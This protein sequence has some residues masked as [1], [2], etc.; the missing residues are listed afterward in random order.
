MDTVGHKGGRGACPNAPTQEGYEKKMKRYGTPNIV[1][2]LGWKERRMQ[3]AKEHV[4]HPRITQI[5][6]RGN[7]IWEELVKIGLWA[8]VKMAV[9]NE[10]GGGGG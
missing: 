10:S 8:V 1:Q 2:N 9:A 3:N 7:I 5:T 4:P 6:P